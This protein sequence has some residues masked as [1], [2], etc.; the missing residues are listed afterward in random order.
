ML[1][2]SV[3]I[4]FLSSSARVRSVKSVKGV[5]FMDGTSDPY[6]GHQV[7]LGSIKNLFTIVFQVSCQVTMSPLPAANCFCECGRT[8]SAGGRL[9]GNKKYSVTWNWNCVNK[10]V[11][12][13]IYLQIQFCLASI[14]S[15]WYIESAILLDYFY[16][17]PLKVF[18]HCSVK[19]CLGIKE[20]CF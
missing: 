8:T 6:I 4:E 16:T 2:S 19:F 10:N 11:W 5:W 12:E 9:D 15:R 1:A 18:G 17:A 13:L 20:I 3:G 7:Y 14:A